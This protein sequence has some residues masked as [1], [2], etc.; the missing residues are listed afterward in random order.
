MGSAADASVSLL[1]ELQ[2]GNEF[3][4]N[5][6]TG[7]SNYLHEFSTISK[8]NKSSK[9]GENFTAIRAL[10]KRFL[11][12]LNKA[13]GLLP[14]RL[15][16]TSK[17]SKESASHLLDVYRLCLNCLDLVASQLDAKPHSVELQKLRFVRY[18]VEWER[19]QEAEGEA[20]CI[21][22]S[23]QRDCCQGE[24]AKSV[25]S[26]RRELLPP[27]NEENVDQEYALMVL[28][29]AVT[30]VK[31]AWMK[32]S[33][34]ASDYDRILDLVNEALP[35]LKVIEANASDK[36]HQMLLKY[37]SR[38][39]LF[40][41]DNLACFGGHL[42]CMYCQQIFDLYRRSSQRGE[43]WK[44]AH[45][46]CS[47]LFGQQEASD[48]VDVL[49]CI[50]ESMSAESKTG[51]E[52]NAI[53]FLELIHY[54]ANKCR[55]TRNY[56]SIS[57]L[58]E[59]LAINHSGKGISTADLIIGIY[60]TGLSIL[61]LTSHST[62]QGNTK[63]GSAFRLLLRQEN[64]FQ[65]LKSLLDSLKR[66]FDIGVKRRSSSHKQILYLP[67]YFDALS[68]LCH[69]LAQIFISERK[70][71]FTEME[72][73][74][75]V[76]DAFSQYCHLLN[77]C[78]SVLDNKQDACDEKNSTIQVAV[79]GFSLSLRT[80][81]K[82]EENAK[83]IDYFI[84]SDI[85]TYGLKYL[86][87]SL[88]NLA[89]AFY[90]G[91]QMI[92]AAKALKFCSKASCTWILKSCEKFSHISNE[93]Q[94]EIS[95]DSVI[96]F[97]SNSFSKIVN[98]LD[99]VYHSCSNNEV[100]EILT[101]CLKSWCMAKYFFD[102]LPCPTNIIKQFVKIKLGALKEL[103]IEEDAT[104]LHPI[105][106][107]SI[108]Y[109]GTVGLLM[110]EELQ[111][112]KDLNAMNPNFCQK[113]RLKIMS[114]LLDKVYHTEDAYSQRARI[115]IAKSRE[116]RAKG[117]CHDCI[118]CLSEAISTME[119]YFVAKRRESEKLSC[120]DS[121]CDIVPRAYCIRA[122]CTNE[123]EPSSKLFYED[124]H[125]AVRMFNSHQCHPSDQCN[126]LSEAMLNLFYQIIDLL[127]IKGDLN[128]HAEIFE[129]IVRLF[130]L[131][132]IP[133]ETLV[134][135][136]WKHRRI[137][138]ALCT[139]HVNDLFIQALSKHCGKAVNSF[140]YWTNCLKASQPLLVGF[141]MSFHTMFALSSQNPCDHGVSVPP[142]ISDAKVK[143]TAL[144]L[145]SNV[146]LSSA[147]AFISAYLYYDLSERLVQS[148][149]LTEALSYAKDAYHL[150]LALLKGK[151]QLHME[152]QNKNCLAS[153]QIFDSV[154]S[155]AWFSEG[156]SF[157][158]E[159]C[160]L[161]PWNVLQCYLE[162]T[163]QVGI[164]NEILGNGN[165]AKHYLQLGKDIAFSQSLPI[166]IAS[167]SCILGQTY[168][169]QKLWELAE[170]EIKAAKALVDCFSDVS[171]KCI[172][173]F[174]VFIDQLFGDL[175]IN[176][177][178]SNPESFTSKELAHAKEKYGSAIDKLALSK[179]NAYLDGPKAV[180]SDHL[181]LKEVPTKRRNPK[182]AVETVNAS[183]KEEVLESGM[184][185]TRSRY[186]SSIKQ[187]ETAGEQFDT[188]TDLNCKCHRMN[189]W[190]Q[191]PLE[192]LQSGSIRNFIY[193]KW[194]FVR[195]Q[196]L[197]RML[198]S[199]G[200]CL[201][202]CDEN[203]EAHK[204]GKDTWSKLFAIDHVEMIYHICWSALKSNCC[205]ATRKLCSKDNC[206]FSSI[207]ISEIV[208]W[209][210]VAF[211]QSREVPLLFQK[212][213]RLLAA[214]YVLSTSVKSLSIP[215]SRV[216]PE[217]Q[218]ASFFHQASIGAHFNLQ[219]FSATMRQQNGQDLLDI[220]GSCPSSNEA[221]KRNHITLRLAPGSVDSLEDFVQQ[222]FKNLPSSTVVC[223]SLI[224]GDLAILLS[225]L[226]FRPSPI[227]AW[228]LLSRMSS[229]DQPVIVI[230]PI[231]SVLKDTQELC[232]SIS[233]Q[234]CDFTKQWHCPW[235]ASGVID[236]VAPSYRDILENNHF[237]SST[238]LLDDTSE[239]RSLWWKWR[240]QLDKALSKFLQDLEELWLGP[241]KY[242]LLGELSECELL[243]S[244]L[245]NLTKHLKLE[246][247]V[248]VNMTLLKIVLGG[249]THAAEK[250]DC[251][252]QL[253]S[254]NGCHIG[255]ECG[256]MP[257]TLSKICTYSEAVYKTI[258]D[259]AAKLED[260]GCLNRKPSILVLD[261]DLQMLPW[262]NLPIL[263][264][265][266]VY[267][268]PSVG[269]ITATLL[270]RCLHQETLEEGDGLN[271]IP[272]I[273]P[274]DSYYVLNPSGDLSSTQAEF[275]NW[276]NEQNFEGKSGIAPT[277]EE[278][279]GALKKHDLFLY[280]GH[281]SGMQYIPGNEIKSIDPCSASL[282][283]GCS[284]GSL[285]S[286]GAYI[287]QGAPLY[288]LSA[289]SPII[290]AT[291]WDVTDKDID[292][293][294]KAMLE[295][296]FR[297]RSTTAIYGGCDQ[298]MAGVSEEF[299]C[300]DIAGKKGKG[301]KG[302]NKSSCS[303]RHRPRVGSFMGQARKACVLPYLIGAAPVCYGVPTGIT[304]KTD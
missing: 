256:R 276:F 197:Q 93:L 201:C 17:I 289:G 16:E 274:L 176:Q 253:V 302:M 29:I 183:K 55:K 48:I 152:Q 212:V 14:K 258:L 89:V 90:R 30:L 123:I 291:L 99:V 263:R 214:V 75:V 238:C 209:L 103:G 246:Y 68:F 219:L 149:Q 5:T 216:I 231:N 24:E 179:W 205:K 160:I 117:L 47:S 137:S 215:S 1:S 213:S 43:V 249:A 135:L 270:K 128:I 73:L 281:G 161:T 172:V 80:K 26:K 285:I 287:P 244:L 150:R 60:A 21:L 53:K 49:R 211:T 170:K 4:R 56:S 120:M 145:A 115:L 119:R 292:R 66:D 91:K 200:K 32:Q 297:E 125:A 193:F 42:V 84:H 184:R 157:D 268:M 101:D 110:E 39:A 34:D 126:M 96:S 121:A 114:I 70:E 185:M 151:F 222:F 83:F 233:S 294:G 72:S 245:M 27:F 71:D 204:V 275:E 168:F 59:E 61:H 251:V 210:K 102:T 159:S 108:E 35:W 298:C 279:T 45:N 252:S 116:L 147:S 38:I 174:E 293:F 269:A 142:D 220:K 300:L 178:C 199:I 198:I 242:L 237:S 64:I 153:F 11:P 195:R 44:L 181:V 131:K 118:L 167:F 163:L 81:L 227:Q 248:D 92:E 260:S 232:S 23:L 266:E 129:A 2:S 51:K 262:E 122:L 144:D 28:D 264:D 278:L 18:L 105:L 15:S 228:I 280:F 41:A 180:V 202:L 141:Q 58:F 267:R 229:I 106:S 240:K 247:K 303:C 132:N 139:S 50:F 158:S 22:E 218:W 148:G 182:N 171:C 203:H 194:E 250:G 296:W 234:A 154:A 189:C 191:L 188:A 130:Q 208:Y 140:E 155:D 9:S 272:F 25:V 261:F 165:A 74:Y 221:G 76:Q 282:L 223:I 19:Y 12:F 230:L 97:I 301:K 271:S 7:F 259:A 295:C 134:S 304:R 166:F 31:C 78:H 3:S 288:F 37:L 186:R 113:M 107:S 111:A 33:K 277:V 124:I 127:S 36:M 206:D 40:M 224:F 95:E 146:P 265:Q 63:D 239:S 136:L 169:K 8:P 112:Y 192:A 273:D 6:Y 235:A 177:F 257:Q 187:C 236:T 133:L 162:S 57:M 299:E 87:T 164:I 241:W 10:C 67:S 175:Y 62:I 20:F 255:G 13:L 156:V 290:V 65:K 196:L 52:S 286:N 207:N 283:M 225:Q 77:H 226:L 86:F 69:P 82:I 94:D 79:A 217:S 109:K 138:H 143:L 88:Y 254:T 104:L 284:S 190:H 46:M 98:V 54:S 243:D 173:V 85:H 100:D